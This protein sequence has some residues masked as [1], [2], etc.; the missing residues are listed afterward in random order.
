MTPSL[1]AFVVF[2]STD[3]DLKELGARHEM[4]FYN[5]WDH[6]KTYEEMRQG[7]VSS[8]DSSFGMTVP[9]LADPS[10]APKGEHVAVGH[11]SR[12]LSNWGLL[13]RREGAVCGKADAE[14]G[15]EVS[16]VKVSYAHDGGGYTQNHGEIHSEPDGSDL[17]V[18]GFPKTSRPGKAST[19]DSD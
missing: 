3:L 6:E 15:I 12:S 8:S 10:I 13:E 18:G 11:H 17:R 4:F 7:N 16:R 14:G 1:S 19:Q 5:T 9:T 2:L